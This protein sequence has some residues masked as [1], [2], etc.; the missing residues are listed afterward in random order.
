M[1]LDILTGTTNKALREVCDPIVKIDKNVRKLA[2]DMKKTIDPN[3]GMGLAAP[4]VGAQ[5]RMI[6]IKIPGDYFETTGFTGALPDTNIILINPKIITFS[7]TQNLFEEGCLSVPDFYAEVLRPSEVEFEALDENG[8]IIGG[9]AEGIFG[10]ILQHE[11][12]HL[13]GILFTDKIYKVTQKKENQI[14]L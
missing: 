5:K 14:Y 4:Q 11:I 1:I 3:G 8:H 6:L 10:R 7:K 2:R 9:H 12:D 13:D